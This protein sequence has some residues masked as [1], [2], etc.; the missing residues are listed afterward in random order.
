M[1]RFAN[2]EYLYL[3][4]VVALLIVVYGYTS[5][6]AKKR[7]KSFGNPVKVLPLVENRSRVRP[8][9]KFS[10]QILT[11]AL[12]VFTLARPQFGNKLVVNEKSGIEAIIAIDVSNSMLARD[13]APNRLERSKRLISTL[14]EKMQNDRIGIEIFAGEAYPGLPITNDYV[15]ARL[16]LESVTTGMVSLQGTNVAAAIRLADRSFSTKK[17]VGKAII[18][19]TDGE[20]HEQGAIEAAKEAAKNGRKVFVLGVG[21]ED[22]S[23]IPTPDGALRDEHGEVVISTLSEESATEIAKAGE[24]VFIRVD[25]SNNANDQLLA[26]LEQMQKSDFTTKD[27]SSYDEQFQAVAVL[28]LILLVLELLLRETANPFYRRFKFFGVLL[29]LLM[30]LAV[31]AQN[32]EWKLTHRANK[33][34]YE[35]DYKG[36]EELYREAKK[37]YPNSARTYLNLA[38]S[39]LASGNPQEAMQL[40]AEAAKREKNKLI[41][42]LSFHNMGH[43]CQSNKDYAKAI[44][45]YKEALRNNPLDEDT[46]YNLAVCQKMKNEQQEQE[47]QQQ[48]Q[49]NQQQQEQQEQNQ[50]QQPDDKQEQNPDSQNGISKDNAEQL[51]DVAKRAEK[52]TREKLERAVPKEQR[53][54]LKNW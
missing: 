46:R 19:I 54:K 43:I 23:T 10:L 16:Y 2:P 34:F 53:R 37:L 38:D 40:Y 39:Y 17:E 8:I 52:N 20:D 6:R 33:K 49:N 48:Q 28:V 50:Q 41:K 25:N 44:D 47:N 15:S 27:Y 7:L 36:A 24:G 31:N 13:V 3:L 12:I 14:I 45:Y 21:T 22:G 5:L 42:S 11:L 4:I 1:F 51:L 9:V 18:V 30:P 26:V 29:L 35:K 32:E